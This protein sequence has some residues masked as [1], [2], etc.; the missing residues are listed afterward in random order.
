MIPYACVYT[1][2]H[3]LDY[4][5]CDIIVYLYI[6]TLPTL[7]YSLLTNPVVVPLFPNP[8][9]LTCLAFLFFPAQHL[10]NSRVFTYFGVRWLRWSPLPLASALAF[11]VGVAP[12]RG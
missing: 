1:T 11:L 6:V 12:I 3:S 8:S 10:R 9:T 7:R 4:V 2:V 5:L